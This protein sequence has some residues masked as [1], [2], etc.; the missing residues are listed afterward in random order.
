M[1]QLNIT[2]LLGI[3]LQ[4]IFEGDAQNPQTGTFTNPCC[5]RFNDLL[6]MFPHSYPFLRQV[7]HERKL[8]MIEIP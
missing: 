4:Q 3:N 8:E 6:R 1:S 7:W 2:Q 5:L